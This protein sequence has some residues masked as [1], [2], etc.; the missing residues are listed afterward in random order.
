M[1]SQWGMRLIIRTIGL[2][3]ALMAIWIYPLNY[4]YQI[5]RI[6]MGSALVMLS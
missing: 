3:V 5:L 2:A 4:G 1:N 6:I